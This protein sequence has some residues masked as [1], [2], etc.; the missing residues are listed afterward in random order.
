MTAELLANSP[1]PSP[2]HK[3]PWH[4]PLSNKA[5]E[6]LNNFPPHT[7]SLFF[8]SKLLVK[9]L[10]I[11]PTPATTQRA[12]AEIAFS[13]EELIHKGKTNPNPNAILL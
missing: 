2:C 1:P 12:Q 3:T 10:N 6:M 8:D 9:R 7:Y 4:N 5:E 13:E 11:P